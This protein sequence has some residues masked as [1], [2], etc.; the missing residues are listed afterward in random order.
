MRSLTLVLALIILYAPLDSFASNYIDTSG[1][2]IDTKDV[3]IFCRPTERLGDGRTMVYSTSAKDMKLLR[4]RLINIGV[5]DEQ[6]L[7]RWEQMAANND[8]TNR[9][10]L[11]CSAGTCSTGS[12]QEEIKNGFKGCACK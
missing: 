12:C 4:N 6:T 5:T 10:G 1:Q 3:G 7:R 9:A 11:N 2:I 8:C